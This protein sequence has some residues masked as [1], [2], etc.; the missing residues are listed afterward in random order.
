MFIQMPTG[1]GDETTNVTTWEGAIEQADKYQNAARAGGGEDAAGQR[2]RTRAESRAKSR[3][4][5]RAGG[6]K[7]SPAPT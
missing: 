5:S 7:Q 2:P 3:A 4:E 1:E 6:G